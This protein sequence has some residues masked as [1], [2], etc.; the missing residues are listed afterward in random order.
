VISVSR[1]HYFPQSLPE[2]DPIVLEEWRWPV[3]QLKGNS[4]SSGVNRYDLENFQ[5]IQPDV[6]KSASFASLWS[7]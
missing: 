1:E 4:P 7:I 3:A 2:N 6:G 5:L